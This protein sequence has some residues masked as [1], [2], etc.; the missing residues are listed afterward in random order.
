MIEHIRLSPSELQ[1]MIGV[2]GYK[3]DAIKRVLEQYG[4]EGFND[5]FDYTDTEEAHLESRE[6]PQNN[7]SNM[8]DALLWHGKIQGKLLKEWEL[9]G[10]KDE[11][12]FYSVVVWLVGGEVIKATQNQN[13]QQ[14]HPYYMSSFEKVPGAILGHGIPEIISD[15]QSVMNATLRSLVNNLSISSGPQVVV[16]LDRIAA[17]TDPNQLYPWKRWFV[18]SDPLQ[19]D[20][21]PPVEF[22]QPNSNSQELMQVYQVMSN[23]ADEIST[24]P[25]YM[26]GNE[27]VGGA[28]RTASGLSMLM[29]AASKV[30]QSVASN[31]DKD[32]IGPALNQLHQFLL[33]TDVENKYRG[34]ESVRVRGVNFT[35]QKETERVRSLEF[36]QMTGNPIDMNIIGP[37]GRAE[38]LREVAD[39]LGMDH[40]AI[41]PEADEIAVKQQQ[42]AQ[43]MQQA[44][45][46]NQQPGP[47]PG[48]P[49]DSVQ[50]ID[51]TG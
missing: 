6:S 46:S 15:I 34:D 18:D 43:Q 38:V 25:K 10:V 40:A 45:G 19:N 2:K 4:T 24:I 11:T 3:D 22:W 39:A 30:L 8:I 41:V 12:K 44:A 33:K 21:K 36:L 47:G 7:E 50:G 42:I 17:D 51:P 35:I 16:N 1:G 32:I 37:E 26:T 14:R 5:W 20:N 31:V 9:P 27:R 29:G 13:A 28:G 48:N 23:I 49:D